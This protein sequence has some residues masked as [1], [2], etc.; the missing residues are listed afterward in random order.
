MPSWSKPGKFWLH[1]Q[2]TRTNIVYRRPLCATSV[3]ECS[4]SICHQRD[5][6]KKLLNDMLE[7]SNIDLASGYG[8]VEMEPT[9]CEKT[10]SITPF[11]LHQFQIMPFGLCNSP[12][13]F[14]SLMELVLEGLHWSTC[15]DDIIIYIRNTEDHFKPLQEVL[16]DFRTAGLKLKLSKCYLFQTTL[17]TS[18]LN[19]AW[20]PISEDTMCQRVANSNLH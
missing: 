17:A 8:Q 16:E 3:Q 1:H 14:Q 2:S 10:A 18:S 20:K 13:T 12:T 4:S 15:L 6:V 9:D 7:F 5:L 19:M 11:D